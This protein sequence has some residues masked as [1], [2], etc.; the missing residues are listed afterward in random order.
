VAHE[1]VARCK[2]E[3]A[4]PGENET[5]RAE[6]LRAPFDDERDA[7][8]HDEERTDDERRGRRL[9]EDDEGNG[10]GGKRRSSNHDGRPRRSD[11]LDREGEEELRQPGREQPSEQEGP[12]GQNVVR[13]CDQR[14]EPGNSKRDGHRRGRRER[15]VGLARETDAHGDRH[16]AEEGR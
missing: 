8:A 16:R 13:P 5:G 15:G 9:V 6:V 1:I 2:A 14:G 10:D 11:Q 12:G 4:D 3:R 7:A